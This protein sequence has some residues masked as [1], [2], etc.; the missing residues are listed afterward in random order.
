[1]NSVPKA[2]NASAIIYDYLKNATLPLIA[3][4][5]MYGAKLV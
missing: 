1:M 5:S 3:I 2:D 4:M